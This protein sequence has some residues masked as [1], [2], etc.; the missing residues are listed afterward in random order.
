MGLH[1]MGCLAHTC[2]LAIPAHFKH[3]LLDA[4]IVMPNHV[5]ALI[6]I[7]PQAGVEALHATPL[8]LHRPARMSEISPLAGAVPTIVRSYKSAVTRL[9]RRQGIWGS[10]P[11]WQPRY[12]DRIVR[13][14]KEYALIYDYIMDNPNTWKLDRFW[15]NE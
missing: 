10:E 6:R 1:E 5:H 3:V 14:E 2:G 15:N 4:F 7:E 9:A 8:E 11:L 12:H 13:N